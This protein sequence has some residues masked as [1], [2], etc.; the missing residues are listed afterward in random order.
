LHGDAVL[1]R[2]LA[3]CPREL[4][5]AMRMHAFVSSGWYPIE[6]LAQ[7][8]EA[9]MRAC[10][11]GPELSRA[12]GREGVLDDF[13]TGVNRLITLAITPES[14]L[15]W[16]PRILGLYYDRGRI[17]VE[18]SGEGRGMARFEGFDGFSRPVWEDLIGG[19]LGTL[20]VAGGKTASA[21]VLSGGQDGDS[22]LG[23]AFRWTH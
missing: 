20:E 14:I 11:K 2:T 4:G 19:C 10:D 18:E 22:H 13:R 5:D 15:K 23:V 8:H 6:Q 3:L 17:V 21:R 7:L 16:A 9:A 12:L 1:D